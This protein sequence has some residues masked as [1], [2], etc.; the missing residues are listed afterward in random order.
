[1]CC[2]YKGQYASK[3]ITV[4]SPALQLIQ[5]KSHG[6]AT[7][8]LELHVTYLTL[9]SQAADQ[10]KAPAVG[11]WRRWTVF[12]FLDG[13]TTDNM[14]SIYV[15]SENKHSVAISGTDSSNW[16]GYAFSAFETQNG[17]PRG[18]TPGDGEYNEKNDWAN[19]DLD[20]P[21]HDIFS[22]ED[23][24]LHHPE[25]V[26]WDPR[27]YFL[28]AAMTRMTLAVNEYKYLVQSLEMYFQYQVSLLLYGI[29]RAKH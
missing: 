3:L 14:S 18:H 29:R 10:I 2:L 8:R 11:P 27:K 28:R 12:G 15:I 23:D 22:P 5:D 21:M 6:L 1:M 4:N 13:E 17:A 19:D 24:G 7:F 16:V 9:R 20:E 26:L 25:N